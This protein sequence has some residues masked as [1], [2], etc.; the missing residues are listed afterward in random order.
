M[1]LFSDEV[2]KVFNWLNADRQKQIAAICKRHGAKVQRLAQERGALGHCKV[3]AVFRLHSWFASSQ[4]AGAA[5][6]E[7][8]AAGLISSLTWQNS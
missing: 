5:V 2:V 8:E 1:S 7:C 6:K 3:R 4:A